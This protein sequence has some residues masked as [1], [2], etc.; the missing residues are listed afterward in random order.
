MSPGRAISPRARWAL[1]G[2]QL[3]GLIAI[4][5]ITNPGVGERLNVILTINERW[6]LVVPVF[7]TLWAAGLLGLAATILLPNLWARAFWAFV[8]ALSGAIGF[9]FYLV[10]QT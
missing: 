6:W 2:A 7:L 3:A 9:G 1:F 8:I 4:L 5:I 10:S